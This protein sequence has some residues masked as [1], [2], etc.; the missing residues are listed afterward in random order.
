LNPRAD[1]TH[2][3]AAI[4]RAPQD[5]HGQANF[6]PILLGGEITG[7][8]NKVVKVPIILDRGG[9]YRVTGLGEKI[10]LRLLPMR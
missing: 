5:R 3:I 9:S 8:N 2:P 1:L 4:T 7:M 10:R 6:G